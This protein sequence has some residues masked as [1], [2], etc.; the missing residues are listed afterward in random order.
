MFPAQVITLILPAAFPLRADPFAYTNFRIVTDVLPCVSAHR[1]GRL[2]LIEYQLAP[3]F[4][5]KHC[6]LFPFLLVIA[7]VGSEPY[8]GRVD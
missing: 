6:H 3:C 7:T 1:Y 5:A 8:I 2:R 4:N